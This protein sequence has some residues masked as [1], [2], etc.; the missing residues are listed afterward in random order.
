MGYIFTMLVAQQFGVA[1]LFFP[2]VW[3]VMRKRDRQKLNVGNL[4]LIAGLF[5]TAIGAGVVRFMAIFVVGRKATLD[6]DGGLEVFFF[7][8]LPVIVAI[9]VCAFLKTKANLATEK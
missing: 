9:C 3:L 6:P 8:A 7:L 5:A 2:I 1:L 4:W